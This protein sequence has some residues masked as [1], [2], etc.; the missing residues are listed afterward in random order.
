MGA[1]LF[2]LP[3]LGSALVSYYLKLSLDTVFQIQLVA[4]VV[5]FV[6]FALVRRYI[7]PELCT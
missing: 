7:E 3:V 2:V 6:V 1:V 5:L 4:V